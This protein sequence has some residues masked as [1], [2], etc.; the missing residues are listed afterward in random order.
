MCEHFFHPSESQLWSMTAS[1]RSSV[2]SFLEGLA[3]VLLT[4]S[5]IAGWG[6]A[7]IIHELTET[8]W[9]LAILEGIGLGIVIGVLG[10]MAVVAANDLGNGEDP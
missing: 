1:T 9:I 6:G 5:A 3:I 7:L 8:N 4:I 2:R 10:V